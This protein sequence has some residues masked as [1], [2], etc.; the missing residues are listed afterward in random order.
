MSPMV[1]FCYI[2]MLVFLQPGSLGHSVVGRFQFPR[3]IVLHCCALETRN[4]QLLDGF[5]LLVRNHF[6]IDHDPGVE[7]N[8]LFLDGSDEQV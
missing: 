3:L 6:V 4:G 5:D 1:N 8:F 2:L 7:I